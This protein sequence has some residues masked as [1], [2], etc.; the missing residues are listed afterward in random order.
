MCHICGRQFG[1]SSLLIHQKAC[2]TKFINNENLKAKSQ[3]KDLPEIPLTILDK[4]DFNKIQQWK[5]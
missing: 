5:S 4:F 1:L 2:K 3:Q